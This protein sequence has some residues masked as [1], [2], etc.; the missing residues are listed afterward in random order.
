MRHNYSPVHTVGNEKAFLIQF[1]FCSG[2]KASLSRSRM[3]LNCPRHHFKDHCTKMESC[4][5]SFT[6]ILDLSEDF[7]NRSVAVRHQ[8]R[9][10][11]IQKRSE[12]SKETNGDKNFFIMTFSWEKRLCRT[13]KKREPFGPVQE[14]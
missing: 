9:L 11:H 10:I 5:D 4:E 1:S 6:L 12:K 13:C 2:T 8:M 7:G 3:P 14:M